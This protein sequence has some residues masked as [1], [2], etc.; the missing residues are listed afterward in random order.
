[1]R[2]RRLSERVDPS[3][4]GET[5]AEVAAEVSRGT[6]R[7]SGPPLN[8]DWF[9]PTFFRGLHHPFRVSMRTPRRHEIQGKPAAMSIVVGMRGMEMLVQMMLGIVAVALAGAL[10]AMGMWT[11]T[12]KASPV[13]RC[14]TA[15]R[16]HRIV[17]RET[18]GFDRRY[19]EL[20]QKN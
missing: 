14:L 17:K 9:R 20:L 1:L 19:A 6:V 15:Y 5:T 12:N 8:P 11:L 16:I 4:A 3:P 2:W 18:R 13:A 10:Y 7:H